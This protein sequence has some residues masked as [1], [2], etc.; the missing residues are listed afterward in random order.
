L[1]AV[2]GTQYGAG[3]GSTTFDLPHKDGK[4]SVGLKPGDSDFTPL[5]MGGGAKSHTLTVAE[6][7]TV[8]VLQN[9]H[10]HAQNS[11]NHSQDLHDHTLQGTSEAA[12]SGVASNKLLAGSGTNIYK[13][14]TG[15][16]VSLQNEFA[17]GATATNIA[18]T[19]TNIAST[20]TNQSFGSGQA[21]NNMPPYLVMNYIIR[22]RS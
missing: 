18:S 19:A 21:H 20:A 13:N 15:G 3:D 10:N 14:T 2:I 17:L 9:S 1:F 12:G 7:P 11:H 5:G 22:Y 6:L 8:T 4:V 16:L